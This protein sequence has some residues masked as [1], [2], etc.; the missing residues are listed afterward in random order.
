MEFGLENDR[1]IL[2]EN[3]PN[4]GWEARVSEEADDEI[5]ADLA[6]GNVEWQFEAQ[7]DDGKIRVD[8]GQRIS[9]PVAN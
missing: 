6:R 1:L 8:V 5:E 7:L 9:G 3:R 2:V 4:E